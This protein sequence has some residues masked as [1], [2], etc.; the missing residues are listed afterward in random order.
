MMITMNDIFTISIYLTDKP[1]K[2]NTNERKYYFFSTKVPRMNKVT[3]EK[4]IN[5]KYNKYTDVF[6][7]SKKID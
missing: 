1:K 5:F 2:E 6:T 7:Y 4:A 3:L